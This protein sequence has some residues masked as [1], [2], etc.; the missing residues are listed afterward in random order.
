MKTSKASSQARDTQVIAGIAAHFTGA[1]KFTFG[2]VDY[3][4]TEIQKLL[5]SRI[6]AAS[7]TAAAR[8]KWLTAAAA[9]Q[10]KTTE[11]ESVL[12]ALKS[13]LVTTYGAKSQVVADFGFT[14][15]QK[16]T[17]AKTTADAVV[18]REATRKARGTMGKKEK[19]KITGV[20]APRLRRLRRPRRLRPQDR[21][22]PATNGTTPAAASSST[23]RSSTEPGRPEKSGERRTGP[24][25]RR[26]CVVGLSFVWW[27]V[28]CCRWAYR[29]VTRL[30]F[31]PTH[32]SSR[33]SAFD[34]RDVERLS[35]LR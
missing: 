18:K 15:K 33:G 12:L 8:A 14:P 26:R 23:I 35:P 13:H 30:R 25:T 21:A 4:A 32:I 16:E 11:S 3:K 29:I 17:T 5:Q 9:E 7:A 10:E 20:V 28:H 27:G 31:R 24:A 22:A 2:G 1:T 19:L 6:D 34:V